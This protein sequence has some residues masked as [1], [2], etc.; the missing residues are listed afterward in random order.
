[1]TFPAG[2]VSRR[3]KG[4]I[5]DTQWHKSFVSKAV[6]YK[7]DVVPIH[8]SGRC[9]NFFYNLA[10]LRKFLG[11]KANLEMFFLPRETFRHRNNHYKISVGK[12]ISYKIF[13]KRYKALEWASKVKD[14]CYK[15]ADDPDVTFVV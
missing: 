3:T 7:R 15:L 5:I 8:V 12:P 11:I 14:H 1:M 10:N 13:D 4:K 2:L 9:S 6:K